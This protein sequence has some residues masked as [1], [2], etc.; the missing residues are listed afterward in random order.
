MKK[1]Q[2]L[3]A[4]RFIMIMFIVFSHFDPLASTEETK[5]LFHAFL[6]HP[7]P[8]VD[9]FF[10][11]SGFGMMYSYINKGIVLKTSLKELCG[12][13]VTH[14]RKIYKVYLVALLAG[15]P[16]NI[17]YWRLTNGS[18]DFQYM[19]ME[20]AKFILCIP[21]LQSL[22]GS[23]FFSHAFNG[24]SWFLSCLFCVYIVSPFLLNRLKKTIPI[25]SL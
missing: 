11:L 7:T 21:L 19:V 1:I 25:Y 17:I 5:F 8:A 22:S 24:V 23:T 2:S 4:I 15:F 13:A 10:V 14:V 12:F 16:L 3:N 9:Y 18:V 20:L 6:K